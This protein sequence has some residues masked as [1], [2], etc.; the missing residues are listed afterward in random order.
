MP[1]RS[2]VI[3]FDDGDAYASFMGVWS[4][5]VGREMLTWLAPAQQQRWLDVG[6]GNGAFTA[7]IAELTQP[8]SMTGLDPSQ[9]QLA[10][11]RQQPALRN[12]RF[13]LGDAMALPF[14]NDAFDIA[15]MP[16][17]LAFVPDPLQGV[18]EMGRVVRDGGLV[19]ATMWDLGGGGFPYQQANAALGS[20]GRSTPT[21]PSPEASQPEVMASL[22]ARAGLGAIASTTITVTRSFT[23]FDDYWAIV[24]QGPS[25]GPAIASLEAAQRAQL[26]SGLQQQLQ[27]SD[28]S[29]I[30]L[31]GRATAI[32]GIAAAG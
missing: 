25:L 23:S 19:A 30:T 15:V 31:S 32:R 28:G 12:A 26:R 24:C 5:L 16:L 11:A 22:W 21:P 17:M 18:L 27:P 1:D 10:Y 3:R 4:Q 8:R 29:A 6:C 14:D 7:L 20:L 13:A 9:Q 2:D